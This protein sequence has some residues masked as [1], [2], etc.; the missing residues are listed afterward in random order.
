MIF[1]LRLFNLTEIIV[2]NI[3]GLHHQVIGIR[4]YEFVTKTQF[5]CILNQKLNGVTVKKGGILLTLL[6]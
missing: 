3:K 6:N 5:L 2:W 4:K 1:K